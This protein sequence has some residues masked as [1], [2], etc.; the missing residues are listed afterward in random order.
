L[1]GRLKRYSLIIERIFFP[2]KGPLNTNQPSGHSGAIYLPILFLAPIVT[3]MIV[4][5]IVMMIVTGM[6]AV[7]IAV[8]IIKTAPRGS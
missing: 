2:P 7:V 5:P 6:A 4:I 1:Q 3:V 8:V